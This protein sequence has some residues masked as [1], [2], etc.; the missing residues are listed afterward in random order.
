MKLTGPARR[1]AFALAGVL[2][3]GAQAHPVPVR[4][5]LPD[6]DAPPFVYRDAARPG[7]FDRLLTDAGRQAGLKVT[8]LR[9][10]SARCR[11]ALARGDADAM[12][13]PIIPAYLAE[14]DFPLGPNGQPD[15]ATRMG[16]IQFLLLRRRGETGPDWDGQRLNPPGLTVGVRRGVTTLS[17]RLQALGVTLDDR[18]SSVE[19]LLNKLLVRRIDLA[20]M[21]REEFLAANASGVEALAQ[22]LASTDLHLAASRS[23]P[24]PARERL[25]AWR[26]QI[27]RL[28]D[29]PGYRPEDVRPPG[30]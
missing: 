25:A 3:W 5:C 27:V 28:R 23:L 9:L 11:Q 17:D 16:R 24:G 29:A 22:P 14:L 6:I 12:P 13:L 15:S 2:A 18:T 26:E 8:V 19:Q 30:P 10:P 7:I 21:T 4:V 1:L 20:A